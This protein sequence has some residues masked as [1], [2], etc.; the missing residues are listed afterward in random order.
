LSSVS[1]NRS[2]RKTSSATLG[3]QGSEK[4][5]QQ[6][7][8]L[9]QQF[10]QLVAEVRLLE[11]YYQEIITRQQSA[12]AGLIDTRAALEAL[13]GLSK[14]ENNEVLVP[15]GGGSL[16]PVT[17]PPIERLVISVGAGIAIEKSETDAKSFLTKRRQELEKAV[18]SL[19]QQ[20]KEIGSRLEVGRATLQRIAEGSNQ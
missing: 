17:A 14:S 2:S 9:Q 11:A 7:Q 19:E 20:R 13:E 15:I 1:T 6:Q 18:T 5:T 8:Q 16:I 4:D 10:N 12:S 3:I